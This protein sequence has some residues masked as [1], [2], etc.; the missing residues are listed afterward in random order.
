M[1]PTLTEPLSGVLHQLLTARCLRERNKELVLELVA[2]GN[3]GEVNRLTRHWAGPGGPGGRALPDGLGL[4]V[5]SVL[6]DG[7]VVVLRA[8]ARAGRETWSLVAELR[9]DAAGRVAHVHD[10]LVPGAQQR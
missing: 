6:A 5:E 8:T 7:D 4:T 9:F 10:I 1:A 2:A 3:R